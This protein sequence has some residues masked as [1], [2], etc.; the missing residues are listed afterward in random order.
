[1]TRANIIIATAIAAVTVAVLALLNRPEE[2]PAWPSRIQGFAFSPMRAGQDASKRIYPSTEEIEADLKLL[3]GRSYAVRTYTMDGTLAEVAPLAAKYGLNVA[4][5]AWISR[6]KERSEAEAKKL[7][8]VAEANRNVVRLIVGN[9]VLYRRELPKEQL[10]GYLDWVQKQTRRPVSTAETWDTWLRNPDLADHVDYIAAHILPYWEGVDAA[11]AV[12]FSVNAVNSLKLAFPDKP[13]VIAEV[14]WPSNGRTIRKAEASLANEATFLRRFLD[15]AEKDDYVYYVMEAF[16][17][18]WKRVSEGAV[19]A[20]WG[21]WDVDRQPKFSF[22]EPVVPEPHWKFLGGVSVIIAA[23]T[24]TLMVVPS[25][26]LKRRG[27]SF[28][29]LIAYAAATAGVWIVYDYMN[30]YLTVSGVVVGVLL[31]VGM[32]G[33]VMV[34]LAEAHEWA[35]ALWVTERRREVTPQAAPDDQLPM[36]SVHVPAYNEPPD[37]LIR[38]LQAL[39]TLDYPRF[40]VL[41]IDNNT[42]DPAIW[43]PVRA[44]C[45]RLGPRFRFFH[46]DPLAGFKAGALNFALRHTAPEAEIVAVIDSDYIVDP[47]WLRQ[48]A[49]QFARPE[50]AIVQAPQDYSDGTASAFKAMCYSEYAGFFYIGMITRNERNAIIQ[51]GTMTMVRRQVLEAVRGWAEWCITEDAELGLRVF[52]EGYEALYI[53]CSYGKGVMP[54][55]FMDFKKQRF[56]WAYGAVQ[57]LRHHLG[58]LLGWKGRL[59]AGQRYHF[60]AGWLPWFADAFNLFF[61]LAALGWSIAMIWDPGQFYPPLIGFSVLPLALFAFKTAKLFYIYRTRI[62]ASTAQTLAGAFAGLALAHTISRAI[63]KGVVTKGLPFFRTPKLARR[64][65]WRSALGAA[66][67][68]LGMLIALLAA[69]GAVAKVQGTDSADLLLWVIVLLLQAVPYLA[70]VVVSVVGSFPRLSAHR[71]GVREMA[72][73]VDLGSAE[74]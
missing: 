28:L 55:T 51:H 38:S 20:Y 33:V 25:R 59:S 30:Q 62:G 14:G 69:A 32:I 44:H 71:I 57:I 9:E 50:V 63:M 43:G 48:L 45:E 67:E 46:V 31:L 65:G 22:D 18:P 40:E 26:A 17:Q 2:E 64:Q 72:G 49:P 29:A 41:V 53:P 15:L 23:I 34:L 13:L 7:V 73:P 61:N 21:V 39:A 68:E 16:D 66:R 24:F 27:R 56:R 52:D 74:S 1:M 10:I 47:R 5:G 6:D 11:A 58:K 12:Q 37:L 35:E 36:V 8:Q 70:A 4:L 54:D 42:K 19:G 3:Q 60:V